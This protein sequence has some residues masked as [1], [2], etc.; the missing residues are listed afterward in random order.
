[1]KQKR[2]FIL[3]VLLCL[4]FSTPTFSMGR[5]KILQAPPKIPGTQ[6]R[7]CQ[8]LTEQQQKRQ[9]KMGNTITREISRED[10]QRKYDNRYGTW[11]FWDQ[12][13][14]KIAQG[15]CLP[16]PPYKK[17]DHHGTWTYWTETGL[18]IEATWVHGELDGLW[19]LFDEEGKKVWSFILKP[20][21]KRKETFADLKFLE[22]Q[23]FYKADQ[24]RTQPRK[25]D[26]ETD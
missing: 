10:G 14:K 22:K 1:M 20:N 25:H 7:F 19:T 21:E 17:T 23:K 8:P 4:I 15:E 9:N 6:Y 11:S 12:S 24:E 26:H 3:F 18:K 5:K 13:N 16:T 2:I